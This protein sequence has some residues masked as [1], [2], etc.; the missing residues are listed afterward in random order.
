MV[1]WCKDLQL[2]YIHILFILWFLP[3]NVRQ[4]N[5][6]G[7]VI[8]SI[9]LI[10]RRIIKKTTTDHSEM[11]RFAMIDHHSPVK[12]FFWDLFLEDFSYK[13]VNN[14]CELTSCLAKNLIAPQSNLTNFFLDISGALKHENVPTTEN[15]S[16]NIWKVCSDSSIICPR[17]GLLDPSPFWTLNMEVENG[18]LHLKGNDPIRRDPFLTSMIV[19]GRV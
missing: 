6:N 15:D 14:C 8:Y 5:L 1:E 11:T 4:F 16:K 2:S 13:T 3:W 19:G 10:N 18:W 12:R 9:K 7:R 17:V